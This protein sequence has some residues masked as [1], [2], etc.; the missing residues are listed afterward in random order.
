VANL[1]HER[2]IK[3]QH[4]QNQCRN[5]LLYS[6]GL[7]GS[8]NHDTYVAVL[9]WHFLITVYSYPEEGTIPKTSTTG[10]LQP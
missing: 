10:V 3:V 7:Y 5:R 2:K 9:E 6:K 8:K 4:Q 1:N